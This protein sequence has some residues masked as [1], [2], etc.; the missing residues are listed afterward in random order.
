MKQSYVVAAMTCLIALSAGGPSMAADEQDVAGARRCI[1][2]TQV[3]D[4]RVVDDLNILFYMRGKTVYHNILPRQCHGLA[5]ENRFSYRVSTG[6]LCSI[7]TIQILY[8]LGSELR[9][10][11]SCQLGYFHEIS[12]EDADFMIDKPPEER[13]GTP[14]SEPLPPADPEDVTKDTGE[15]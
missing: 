11:S 5:R 7:D 2:A 9:P 4:T 3:R 14:P 6:Q 13:R 12:E 1:P 8:N 10:G 15:S